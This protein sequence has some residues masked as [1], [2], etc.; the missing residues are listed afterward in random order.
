[1]FSNMSLWHRIYGHSCSF[2]FIFLS[3]YNFLMKYS[4]NKLYK[5]KRKG[6]QEKGGKTV[7]KETSK[8][9]KL[10]DFYLKI[11]C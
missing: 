6:M 1:M 4:K 3:Q 9:I 5:N 7:C 2:D 11:K 8:T 10:T